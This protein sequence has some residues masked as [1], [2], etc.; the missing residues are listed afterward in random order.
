MSTSI[1]FR[2]IS[3]LSWVAPGALEKRRTQLAAEQLLNLLQP[4]LQ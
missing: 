3:L 2:D 4:P 1:P